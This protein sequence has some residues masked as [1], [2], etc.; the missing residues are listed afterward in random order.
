MA[1]SRS[2]DGQSNGLSDVN[3]TPTVLKGYRHA[4]TLMSPAAPAVRRALGTGPTLLPLLPVHS[5]P[6]LLE[7]LRMIFAL[8]QL[9]AAWICLPRPARGGIVPYTPDDVAKL[10]EAFAAARAEFP[11]HWLGK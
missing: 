10:I 4:S 3:K 9:R 7:E 11:T 6:T 8:P 1:A 2:G 5:I